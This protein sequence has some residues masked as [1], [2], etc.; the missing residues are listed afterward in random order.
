MRSE[1]EVRARLEEYR[2]VYHDYLQDLKEI[3][4]DR[5]L[6]KLQKK[7][8]RNIILNIQKQLKPQIKALAWV[9]GEEE[10]EEGKGE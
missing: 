7:Q 2:A 8:E 9:M 5:Q 4:S 10:E 3:R 1:A 6:S